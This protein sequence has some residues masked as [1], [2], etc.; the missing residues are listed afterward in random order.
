M[1]REEAYAVTQSLA[2]EAWEGDGA[3]LDLV[4]ADNRTKRLLTKQQIEDIFDPGWYVR[5]T[6]YIFKRV[7][8]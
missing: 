2:R 7:F 6:D 1:T 3:F 8:S 4:K 5:H